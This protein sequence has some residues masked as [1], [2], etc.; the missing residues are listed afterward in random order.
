ML[1][2]TYSFSF[3]KKSSL[4]HSFSKEVCKFQEVLIL[5]MPNGQKHINL[6]AVKPPISILNHN[7]C[8]KTHFTHYPQSKVLTVWF[9]T[10]DR[11]GIYVL[12]YAF[13]KLTSIN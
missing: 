1:S 3:L 13:S 5:M 9:E 7:L 6:P 2:S 12:K 10:H 11:E 4:F 8:S